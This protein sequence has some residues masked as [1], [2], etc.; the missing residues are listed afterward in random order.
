MSKKTSK[1]PLPRASCRTPQVMRLLEENKNS[2]NEV[3]LAGKS[4]IPQKLRR[5]EPLSKIMRR[6]L[7]ESFANEQDTVVVNITELAI[8]REAPEVLDR[9]NACSCQK[10][11]EAFSMIIAEKVPARFARVSDLSSKQ[12]ALSDRIEPMRKVVMTE[13]I[14]ELICTGK[15]CYHDDNNEDKKDL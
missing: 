5:R 2:P 7:G 1:E 14:R 11:V 10:C 9:F 6:D 13:M 3:I 15:R 8:G 4:R 12:R